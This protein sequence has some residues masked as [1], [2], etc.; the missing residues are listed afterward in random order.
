[1][2]RYSFPRVS[3]CG[4]LPAE[5]QHEI[6]TAIEEARAR[7]G[8][9]KTARTLAEEARGKEHPLHDVL[10]WNDEEAANAHRAN[11]VSGII[12]L[13]KVT[14]KSNGDE[15]TIPAFASVTF[16][17][18]ETDEEAG[19]ERRTCNLQDMLDNPATRDATVISVV[20][21][22]AAHLPRVEA[23]GEDLEFLRKAI[24]KAQ[25]LCGLV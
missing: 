21:L 5:K 22:V 19:P 14:T 15:K 3:L 25:R 23:C 6:G 10:P 8:G 12:S 11:I 24:R 18:D 17:E 1:M 2:V 13:V 7:T 16:I 4:G 20:K 9:E